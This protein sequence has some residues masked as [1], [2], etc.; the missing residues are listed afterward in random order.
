MDRSVAPPSY[1]VHLASAADGEVRETEAARL[2]PAAA[3][4]P[5]VAGLGHRDAATEGLEEQVARLEG[6]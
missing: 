2:Q 4:P 3:P 1:G 6:R 5:E